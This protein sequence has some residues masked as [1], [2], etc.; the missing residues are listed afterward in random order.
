MA[1]LETLVD[2]KWP[3]RAEFKAFGVTGIWHSGHGGPDV[4][5]GIGN[6]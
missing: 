4:L 5:T 2:V 1:A 3:F 6:G